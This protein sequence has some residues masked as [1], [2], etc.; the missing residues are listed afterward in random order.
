M[1]T[2]LIP[3]G[4]MSEERMAAFSKKEMFESSQ[5]ETVP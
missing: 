5:V 3:G 2:R 4:R 1:S